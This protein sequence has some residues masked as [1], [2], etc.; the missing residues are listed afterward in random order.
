LKITPIPG[1]LDEDA[2]DDAEPSSIAISKQTA[3]RI[4]RE[5]REHVRERA[6]IASLI[7]TPIASLIRCGRAGAC[8]RTGDGY[9]EGWA[10][11]HR[12]ALEERHE[13]MH[14]S[15]DERQPW[16]QQEHAEVLEA[17]DCGS[18][19]LANDL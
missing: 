10:A 15:E 1:A 5:V 3:I 7:A 9:T 16:S 11:W 8:P 12:A 17:R 13:C 18:Q 2:H 14:G 4:L 6:L 19:A